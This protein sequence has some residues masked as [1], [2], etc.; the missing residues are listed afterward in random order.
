MTLREVTKMG[1]YVSEFTGPEINDAIK[2]VIKGKAGIQG[3]KV[4]GAEIIPDSTTNK[5]DLS[6][7]TVSQTTGASTTSTMSQNAITN[8]LN[9]KANSSSLSAVATS[10]SYSD[11]SNKPTIPNVSQTTGTST[12]STMSQ[13]AITNSLNN[14]Q[15]NITNG[16]IF[17][18]K[19]G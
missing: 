5:V 14:K 7:P 1:Q 12:T 4:N 18:V 3:V 16:Y 13:N 17:V 11:L 19:G 6:I 2:N 10:G 15:N 8:S 9:S